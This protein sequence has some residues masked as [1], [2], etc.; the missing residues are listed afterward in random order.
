MSFKVY[1]HSNCA[2]P[3]KR[4]DEGAAGYDLFSAEDLIIP[5]STRKLVS[6]DIS[7]QIPDQTY[8]RVAPR[9]GLSVKNS[10]DIGAGVIDQSYRGIVRV[11]MINNGSND[12]EVKKGDRI[13]QLIIERC[14]YPEIS[15]VNSL[16]EL[17]ETSRGSGGFGS[18]G[19]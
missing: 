15:I 18:T 9:S 14:F 1:L 2:Q 10:I 19:R 5:K 3:P 11:L 8:A 13:A 16:E 17:E 4:A 7:I 12:F 6:T